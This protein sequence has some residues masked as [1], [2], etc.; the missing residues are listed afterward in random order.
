MPT[1]YTATD[2]RCK[3]SKLEEEILER[4]RG[5]GL[6]IVPQV[7]LRSWVF[8]AAL[9]GTWILIEVN[10]AYWHAKQHAKDR[11]ERK[12][13]WCAEAGYTLVTISEDDYRSHPNAAIQPVLA[14]WHAAEKDEVVPATSEIGAPHMSESIDPSIP[15][16][17][18]FLNELAKHGIV[19]K[20]CKAAKITRSAAYDARQR[21]P[22]FAQA[23]K[24]ALQDAA[25]VL[26]EAYQARALTQSDRAVEFLLRTLDP[27]TY[28]DSY[29]PVTIRIDWASVPQDMLDAYLQR[30]I[31]IDD[32][33]EYK[34]A[35]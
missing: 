31:T 7:K 18:I 34:A 13:A 11:D 1:Y 24:L 16:T 15:W 14:A 3:T 5:L 9:Q 26:R 27:E 8:D 19:G 30:R 28:R 20:A 21:D 32:L 35:G 4:L 23:W 29:E 2:R 10:G 17:T 12:R 33:A 25:D 6:P 22:A